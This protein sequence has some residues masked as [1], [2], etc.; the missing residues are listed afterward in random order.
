[1]NIPLCVPSVGELEEAAVVEALRSGWVAPAGPQLDEFELRIGETTGGRNAVAVSSGTAALH[2][3]FLASGIRAGDLVAVPTLT[4]IATVNALTYVG[5]IPVFIDCDENGLINPDL[6]EVALSDSEER[7]QMIKAVIAVDLYGRLADYPRIEEIARRH[8][9]RV[10]SDAAES[11]GAHLNGSPGGSFGALAALSFNGNK[12]ITTSSGGA[13]LCSEPEIADRVRYLST[14]ARQPVRHYEHTEVGYNY[15]L[16]NLLASLGLAQLAR[17]GD[18]VERKRSHHQA[19]EEAFSGKVGLRMLEIAGGNA[20]MNVLIVGT[21]F[22]MTASELGNVLRRNGIE[23]R[24]VFKPMH[25]Q[26]IHRAARL[27]YI[28]GTAERLYRTGIVL[29]SSTDLS[30]YDCERVI[31]IVVPQTTRV[32]SPQ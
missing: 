11:L 29:P 30:I 31:D 22:P 10:L 19:Y 2:L 24:P 9:A 17:L 25:L 20:W 28:N 14:Q 16:S 23:T 6:L 26:P 1:M 12:I 4:F 27:E 32:M 15:R 21:E 3:M 8:G 18:I 5:G 13:V 7:G